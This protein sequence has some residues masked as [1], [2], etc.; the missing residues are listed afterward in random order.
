VAQNPHAPVRQ[1]DKVGNQATVHGRDHKLIISINVIRAQVLSLAAKEL[2]FAVH[3]MSASQAGYGV[4]STSA[5][6]CIKRLAK[7]G[8]WTPDQDAGVARKDEWDVVAVLRRAGQSTNDKG[9][10]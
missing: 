6:N 9:K 8:A 1:E 2:E 10:T 7:E 4:R 3:S 5:V